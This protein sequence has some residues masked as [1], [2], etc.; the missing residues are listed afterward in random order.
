MSPAKV[1][2]AENT[3]PAHRWSQLDHARLGWGGDVDPCA[4]PWQGGKRENGPA[5]AWYALA[6]VL[7]INGSSPTTALGPPGRYLRSH[8]IL[9]PPTSPR[10]WS[11]NIYFT[12]I[13]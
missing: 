4:N 3:E 12:N 2:E 11:T 10:P 7:A 13:D 5:N 1:Q 9:K 8:Q 6:T